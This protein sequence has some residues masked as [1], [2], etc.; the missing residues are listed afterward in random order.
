[1]NITRLL[2]FSTNS[3]RN[4][5]HSNKN[6]ARYNEKYIGLNVKYPISLSDSNLYSLDRFSRNTHRSNFMAIC[7]LGAELSHVDGQKD[8]TILTGAIPLCYPNS[9]FAVALRP[10]A[11]HS[12]LIL[13]V[14]RSH[15]TS[16]HS[17]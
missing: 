12:F 1:M 7:P 3:A 10:N 9:F 17:R 13:D 14:S 15:T 4:I 6:S 5:S 11:G 8:M 2:I 16:H